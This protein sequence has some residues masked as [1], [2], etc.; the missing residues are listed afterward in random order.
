[1]PPSLGRVASI[2]RK[3]FIQIRRD[4][5]TLAIILV[6]PAIQLLLFGYGVNT[7]VDHIPTVVVD[8]SG[9]I[10]SRELIAALQNSTYFDVQG[11]VASSAEAAAA[12]DAGWAKVALILPPDFGTR[13]LRGETA[14]AQLLVD[15]SDPNVAQTAVFAAGV[16]A[17]VRSGDVVA[18]TLARLGRGQVPGG[19]E[20]RPA[21]LY[22]PG[23]QSVQFMVPGLIGLILQVQAILLTALAVVRERERGTLEQL[24]V[25]PIRSWE[26]MVGKVIPYTATSFI[27]VSLALLIGRYWFE[28]E[29][30]GNLIL[31]ALFSLVFLLGSLGIGLLI[32]TISQTQTQALQ[33]GQFVLLPSLLLSGFMFPREGMPLPLQLVGLFIPLTYFLQI[34]RGIILKGVG[35]DVLWPQALALTLFGLLV[36]S[37]S[38]NRFVKRLG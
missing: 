18:D 8:Q 32:S 21:V 4:R 3:E 29:I 5:R 34:L 1:M 19:F 30:R 37:V 22:N 12:I 33:L 16:V 24:V 9:D 14:L 7:I 10:R 26:L 11:H 6:M 13:A 27:A 28:V 38:A 23:M 2:I 20:L 35:I 36:F 15:G 31:L 17:Q 25:T